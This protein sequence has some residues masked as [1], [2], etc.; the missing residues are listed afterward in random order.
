M[1][2]SRKPL[3]FRLEW[4]NRI[5]KDQEKVSKGEESQSEKR[6]NN[7]KQKWDS[8]KVHRGQSGLTCVN[9]L[10]NSTLNK[11]ISVA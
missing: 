7:F 1:V 11:S 10:E 6:K 9:V 5:S 4:K 2:M 8:V 3:I